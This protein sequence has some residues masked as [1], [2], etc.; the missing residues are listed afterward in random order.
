MAWVGPSGAS[1]DFDI[2]KR[3]N[4][5]RVHTLNQQDLDRNF[6]LATTN[7]FKWMQAARMELPWMQAGYR[8][9][10]EVEP[11]MTRR[12]LVGSQVIRLRRPGALMEAVD[13]EVATQVEVGDV[14][15][16]TLEFRYKILF[17]SQQVATGSTVMIS[18][19]GTPGNFK[20]HPVPDDVKALAAAEAS[21]DAKFMRETLASVAK[22]APAGAYATPVV[23]RYSDEDVNKHAN[24]SAQARYFED[25][26]E[27]IAHDEAAS[28]QLR[29]VAEQQLEAIVIS[30]AAEVSAMD[31][32]EVR[33]A[34]AQGC[35]LD[36]W[37]QRLQ[38][39]P[40]L[41]ARGRIFCGGGKMEDSDDR[42]LRS[43]KL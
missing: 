27:V 29:E 15:R 14:G 40:T 38:P 35:T 7:I 31:R 3:Q 24:H 16:T 34:A 17:G 25:A 37:V 8:A 36:V 9:F 32:L 23:V 12:L 13:N 20:P 22:E 21:A 26:K 28:P 39:N 42:R 43:S 11:K 10:C 6:C 1:Y 18:T 19:A 30:Y 41:V 2:G 33:V 4:E 5:Y